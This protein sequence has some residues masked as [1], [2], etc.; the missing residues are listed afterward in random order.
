[1]GFAVREGLPTI[2]ELLSGG[3]NRDALPWRLKVSGD[4]PRR[5]NRRQV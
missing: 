2:R 1:M 3:L 4:L 5:Y